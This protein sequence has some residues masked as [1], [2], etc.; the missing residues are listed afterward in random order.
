MGFHYKQYYLV[1]QK[2]IGRFPLTAF[3]DV[4][5]ILCRVV[6]P[7]P[8]ERLEQEN[9]WSYGSYDTTMY[10]RNVP[11]MDL[12]RSRQKRPGPHAPETGR[13]KAHGL[14]KGTDLR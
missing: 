7:N 11:Q 12:E 4:C 2:T 1:K 5:L 6:P 10:T 13:T 3:Y 9:Q 8:P 14:H